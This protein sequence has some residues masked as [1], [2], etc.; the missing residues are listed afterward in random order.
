MNNDVDAVL[1]A[2]EALDRATENSGDADAIMRLFAD[3]A[4]VTFWGSAEPEEAVGPMSLRALAEAIVHA[5]GSFVVRWHERR[6]SVEGD[7]AWVHASGTAAWD[8][9][10]GN[11]RILPYRA[12]AVAVRRD[13]AWLWHTF[14]GS[15]PTSG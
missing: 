1:A 3:D 6:A 13:G 5:P 8:P 2:F 10:T 11:V 15:E 4:Q 7:V 12:T 14:N 9:G